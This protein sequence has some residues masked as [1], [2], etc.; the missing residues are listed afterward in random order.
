MDRSIGRKWWWVVAFCSLS[1]FVYFQSIQHKKRA[2]QELSFRIE[3]I[4]REKLDAEKMKE[5]LLL[6]VASQEDPAWIEMIL[7][8]DL[9]MVPEGWLK[10]HFK[11]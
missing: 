6:A 7:M 10:V 9:G 4:E 8:R 1:I 5:E 3:E 2:I 11:R